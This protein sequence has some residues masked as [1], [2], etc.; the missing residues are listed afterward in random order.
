MAFA[1]ELTRP[2]DLLRLR[3]EGRNLHVNRDGNDGP[4]LVVE[5]AAQPAFLLVQ[6]PPQAIAE[7]AYFEATIVSGA[8]TNAQTVDADTPKPPP[9]PATTIEDPELPGAVPARCR[10][11]A[12]WCS[13]C[14]RT[15]ASR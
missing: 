3:L 12:G 5:D 6:F 9:P 7:S 8:P 4:A 10:T 1:I 15:P 14:R 2:D 11:A 13:R